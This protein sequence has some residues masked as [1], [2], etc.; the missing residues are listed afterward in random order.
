M[1]RHAH[2]VLGLLV[3]PV[4]EAIRL[5]T[6][7]GPSIGEFGLPPCM[8]ERLRRTSMVTYG[9]ERDSRLREAGLDAV[10][11]CHWTRAPDRRMH[12]E[13]Q[14]DSVGLQGTLITGFDG[15][16]LDDEDI[17]CLYPTN[18]LLESLAKSQHFESNW[19]HTGELSL[20]FKH[21]AAAY[22]AARHG[23]R[24][25]LVLEDDFTFTENFTSQLTK[26]LRDPQE[27]LGNKTYDLLF[28]GSYRSNHQQDLDRPAQ[29]YMDAAHKGTI[30]YIISQSG[31]RH[32][33]SHMPITAPSDHMLSNEEFCASAPPHRWVHRPW[34][35][36]PR[37]DFGSVNP[38]SSKL[39]TPKQS[40]FV[41]TPDLLPCGGTACPCTPRNKSARRIAGKG[42]N[43]TS[44]L[45]P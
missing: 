22:E 30:G 8:E 21:V 7:P 36:V 27:W 1:W 42:Q 9:T 39:A 34:I 15:K 26:L 3:L 12:A 16:E 6:S 18:S 43:C 10:F 4:T 32:V 17:G 37:D 38:A 35:V 29:T 20:S 24:N 31:A 2:L 45:V 11:V 33:L 19:L 13:E 41:R 5:Q 14:L 44:A 40:L 23:Y 28:L 25:T